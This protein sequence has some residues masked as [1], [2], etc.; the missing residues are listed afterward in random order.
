MR[1]APAL[2]CYSRHVVVLEL[3]GPDTRDRVGQK[4]LHALLEQSDARGARAG[5]VF[6]GVHDAFHPIP[7]R[8]GRGGKRGDSGKH[9]R[10]DRRGVEPRAVITDDQGH[11]NQAEKTAA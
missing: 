10:E 5:R 11:G 6:L 2:D 8:G 4:H 9:N 3:P 1:D 7:E